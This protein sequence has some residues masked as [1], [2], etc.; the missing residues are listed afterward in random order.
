MTLR[1]YSGL[2]PSAGTRI[3]DEVSRWVWQRDMGRCVGP[4]VGMAPPCEGGLER[5]HVRA[6]HGIGMKSEST[7]ANLV[8]LCG[9]HHRVKTA[10]GSVWRGPLIDYIGRVER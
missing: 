1:R 9:R 7:A 2:K 10:N 5:D 6:S 8:I 3:P 4:L